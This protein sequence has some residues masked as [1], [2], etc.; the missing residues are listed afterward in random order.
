M[1]WT[2]IFRRERWDRERA[3]ELEAYLETETL[4]NLARG[5][6]PEEARYAAQRKLGNTILFREEIYH[7]NSIAWIETLQR[8]LRYAVRV[9]LKNP[10]FLAVAALTLALGVGASTAIFSVVN[11]VLLS[12]LPYGDPDRLVLVKEVLPQI[13][14]APVSVSGPD[15]SQIQK[16][17]HV[18]DAAAGFRLWTYELSGKTEPERITAD[19]TGSDLFNVLG[20]QPVLGRVFTAEE[21]PSGHHVVVLSY[22]LW[23]RRFGGDRSILGQSLNLD[24]QPYTVIGVMPQN[25][26]FPLPG[27]SQ[28]PAAD[29][30]VPLALTKE[31]LSD[32]GDSFDFTVLAKLRSGVGIPRANVDLQIVAQGILDTYQRWARDNHQSLGGIQL[33]LTPQ[34]LIEQVR[35]PVKPLLW[36]L[37]GAVGC[38]L[39]IACVNVANLLLSRAAGR[40]KEMAVRLAMGAGRSGLLRQ[41]LVEGMVLAAAGGALGLPAAIWIKGVLVGIMPANI[42]QFRAI[43]L[44]G[45]VLVFTFLLAA[46]TGLAFGVLPALSASRTD[47][48]HTLTA[49]GRSAT[50]GFGHQRMRATFVVVEVAL[51]VMLL[52][53]AGLLVRSFERVLS[54]NPG[55]RPEHV[56][57]ASIDLPPAEYREDARVVSFFKQ[58]ME[59]LQQS[60]GVVAAG[61]STDLPLQGTWTHLF[62]P[63]GDQRPPGAG[64]NVSNHSVIYGDY[65]PAMGIP[66][67]RG[68]YF[69][70]QD[71]PKSTHVLIVSE[72]LAKKYWPGQNPLGKRLKWGMPEAPGTWM[73]VV[74]VAGDVKQGPLDTA[75]I[76]HT[77]EPYAQLGVLT[78]LRVA[79]RGEGDAESLTA[80]LR[81]AVWGLDH[82]LA[83]GRMRSMEQVI[84]RST[85]ARRFNLFL[86]ASFAALALVLA[87]IGIYGVLAYSVTLR[88]H[89]I[90]VRMALGARA[91]DVLRLVL[92]QGL[93]VTAI[94]VVFGIAG[95]LG[96]TR[97]L[98]GLLFEVRPTDPPTFA[99]VLLLLGGVAL[100]ASYFPARRAIRIEPMVALRHQ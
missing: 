23:Q 48:N 49:S 65:L 60:P 37:L 33:G 36:M 94:G 82:Q 15:I 63:E 11:A 42:P 52:V 2:R 18:F 95:A 100:A 1:S 16:L 83:L 90:G 14:P 43:E 8:D 73:T 67:L 75:T 5:M 57:T 99:A 46:V 61:G 31:E 69:T 71:Q 70:E 24:R 19:R 96:L 87:A 88:T 39:L 72:T 13:G 84:S 68:R 80:T 53:G 21:E 64:A 58:L 56:L 12:P 97:F 30:W 25:F 44:D 40:Q 22:G 59:H 54:T 41:L 91:G 3:R 17:N 50:E 93:R 7:M 76:P 4:D 62:S 45:H 10:G 92:G 27:M 79:V 38:V 6:A 74:G 98:Q 9:L 26:V 29:L 55:F 66:L 35:G 85:S 78:S 32:V 20:V 51:S 86:L 81:T 34:L 47:L 28:G 89:E 77:Y